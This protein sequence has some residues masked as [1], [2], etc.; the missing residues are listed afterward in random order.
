MARR[1][2][3]INPST[4]F[5]GPVVG[6][7]HSGGGLYRDIPLGAIDRAR[8]SYKVWVENFAN[9]FA[10][11]Q[12]ETMGATVT[13]INTPTAATE[14]VDNA[15]GYLEINPGTAA[16]SGSEVQFNIPATAASL[17]NQLQTPGAITSTATLMDGR[18][19]IWACRFGVKATTTVFNG[20]IL[21]GWFTTDTSLMSNTTGVPSVATGGGAGFHIGE[22]GV[23]SYLASQTAITAAGT[24]TGVDITTLGAANTYQWYEVG[25]RIAWVDASAGT[26]TA[27][28]FLDGRKLGEI[29][30]DLPMASTQDYSTTFAVHNGPATV[31]P[32]DLAI[33][34]VM[35]AITGAG[36]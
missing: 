7:K 3:G 4:R 22:D 19:L 35:T 36:R 28:F 14:V 2:Y 9:E 34:W 23:M 11:A 31:V 6:A 1:P 12:L 5:D 25:F 18:E 20:K 8:S 15:V 27:E 21:L 33:D 26:G 30:S 32:C 13:A 16:D 24:S 17:G 29:T 10:D